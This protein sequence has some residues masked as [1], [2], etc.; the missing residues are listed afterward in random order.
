MMGQDGYVTLET[1]LP[2]G[3]ARSEQ[4]RRIANREVELTAALRRTTS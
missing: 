4:S 1:Y 2:F 3:M